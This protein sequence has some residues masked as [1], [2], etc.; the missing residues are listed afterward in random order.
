[1]RTARLR[2]VP[3][4]GGREVLWPGP[5]GREVLWPG[6]GRGAGVVTWSQGGKVL[7]PGPWSTPPPPGVELTHACENI[8]FARFATRTVIATP[9]QCYVAHAVK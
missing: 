1:M 8:I 3:G 9:F 5:G 6:P 7:W 4:E 2:I